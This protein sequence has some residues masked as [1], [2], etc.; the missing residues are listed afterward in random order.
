MLSPLLKYATP[1]L[2]RL[3]HHADATISPM[4]AASALPLRRHDAR[5]MALAMA[6]GDMHIDVIAD[7]AA[8]HADM[9]L[10]IRCLRFR[11]FD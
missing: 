7:A 4:P 9:P 5:L 11:A 1:P 6:R 3:R 8:F 2:R 10:L